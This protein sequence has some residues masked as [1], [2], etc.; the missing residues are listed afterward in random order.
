MQIVTDSGTDYLLSAVNGEDASIHVVPLT[1]TLNG[2]SYR[3]GEVSSRD[4]FYRQLQETGQ[5]PITSQPSAG[6]FAELYRRLALKDPQILSIHISSGLSGTVD[7]ARAGAQMVPEAQ[8]TV[9]DTRTLSMGAG[10]QVNAAASAIRAGWSKEKILERLA[11]ISR[12]CQT[13]FTLKELKYL[14]HGGRISHMKGLLASVLQ[15]KPIIGVDHE[16]GKYVQTG[17]S[18]SFQAA[19]N[20]IVEIMGK[21]LKQG[22][23]LRA[24]VGHA[25]NTAG[26][27]L[28]H[29]LMDN[30]CKCSWL[31]NAQISYVLGAHTGPTLVGLCA[32]P[33][34]LFEGL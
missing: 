23:E 20:R 4:E 12:E 8:V 5:L 1:V 18:R 21:G 30:A 6:E 33:L 31:T 27:D 26:A 13:F 2:I 3:D 29:G 15:I 28:L 7:S 14:I 10:W 34:R 17:Q 25:A 32:A 24:Q 9:V 16:S 19:L 11:A 22:E